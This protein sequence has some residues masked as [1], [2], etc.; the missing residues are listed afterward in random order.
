MHTKLTEIKK[1]LNWWCGLCRTPETL[2]VCFYRNYL[3]QQ[4]PTNRDCFITSIKFSFSRRGGYTKEVEKTKRKNW[5]LNWSRKEEEKDSDMKVPIFQ[6][7]VWNWSYRKQDKV[8][9]AGRKGGKRKTLSMKKGTNWIAFLFERYLK[10]KL[11]SES[12]TTAVGAASYF[13]VSSRINAALCC[14]PKQDEGKS[15]GLHIKKLFFNKLTFSSHA[16][17]MVLLCCFN[18]PRCQLSCIY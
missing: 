5:F 12:W 13:I 18:Y 9:T 17:G 8:Y 6:Q 15:W 10:F 11:R 7:P 4:V 2:G 16:A 3:K 14:V 1:L